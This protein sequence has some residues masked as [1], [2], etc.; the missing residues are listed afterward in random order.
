MRV[1]FLI[2]FIFFS[3]SVQSNE[4][5]DWEKKYPEY[6]KIFEVNKQLY[7]NYTKVDEIKEILIQRLNKQDKK[8]IGK[9][10]NDKV[11][12][13]NEVINNSRKTHSMMIS[14]TQG[15]LFSFTSRLSNEMKRYHFNDLCQNLIWSL[16]SPVSIHKNLESYKYSIIQWG[17][18]VNLTNSELNLVSVT[19]D[20]QYEL[21][22]WMDL[23]CKESL[24]N[25]KFWIVN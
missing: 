21:S 1:L 25:K 9:V 23:T 20:K 22:K 15:L 12:F 5:G 11:E 3:H 6:K 13:L 10:D 7:D 4:Y 18:E 19:L 17:K 24:I 16:P 14:Y 2:F 8:I